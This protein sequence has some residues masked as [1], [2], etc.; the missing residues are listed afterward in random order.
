[1]TD[2]QVRIMQPGDL[3]YVKATWLKHYKEHSEFARPIRDSIYYPAHSRIV[4]HILRKPATRCVVA[5][6]MDE[7]DVILGFLVFEVS[8]PPVIHY[9]YVVSRARKL[10]VATEMMR[11]MEI[12]DTFIFTHRTPDAKTIQSNNPHMTYDPYRI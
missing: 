3:A 11:A 8:A 6:H 7:P 1:M 5:S 12:Q 2:L 4:D 9:A 10:G